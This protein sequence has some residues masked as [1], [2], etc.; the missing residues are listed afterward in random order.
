MGSRYQKVRE[1]LQ[2]TPARWVVTGAAGFIGSHL[3]ETLLR[4]NQHVVGLDNFSTGSPD[5][6]CDVQRCVGAEAFSRFE[7]VEGDILHQELCRKLCEGA[8]YVLHQAALGSVPRSVKDPRT[9]NQVNVDGFISML[10]AARDAKV[11][12]FVY[13]SSSSVYGDA[14]ELPKREDRI[15]NPLS[16]Y[17]ATKRINEMYA[18]I[19]SELYG[20]KSIGLRYFNVFGPRQSPDG[21]YAAVVPRWIQERL[22]GKICLIYGDGTTSRDFCYVDNAVQANILAACAADEALNQEYNIA[23]DAQTSLKDLYGMIDE[24]LNPPERREP[25]QYQEFRSGDVLH[26]RADISKAKRLLGYEPEVSA[27]EGLKRVVRW[28][29]ERAPLVK[30]DCAKPV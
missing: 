16:P 8:R 4:L 14:A 18:H 13:A 7:F 3:V 21:P 2:G 30:C 11:A 10:L 19:F 28:Y 9:S 6:L 15:G 26:S 20:I 25:P 5:N 29:G 27:A 12:R 23:L 17:A 1:S 22:A 24:A